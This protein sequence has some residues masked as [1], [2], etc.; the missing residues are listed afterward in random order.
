MLLHR[1]D[2]SAEEIS[3]QLFLQLAGRAG[4]DQKR[5]KVIFQTYKP[6]HPVISY[7]QNR[8]YERF[9]IENSRLRKDANLFPFCKI[10]LLKLSGEDY[11]LTE[12]ISIKLAKYLLNFC[13]KKNWKLIGPAPSLIAKVGKKFRWQIL[14]HG[15]EGTKIPLPDRSI[16]W[17]LIPK[18]VFLTIDVNPAEL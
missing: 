6:N 1:P 15:P 8:D 5:G 18:N 17:K 7:L 9:L 10:C 12:S 11:E 16:L 13:E 14:I 4:R 2:I 3:L